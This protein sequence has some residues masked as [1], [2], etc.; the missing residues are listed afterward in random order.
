M[1]GGCVVE[2]HLQAFLAKLHP[3]VVHARGKFWQLFQQHHASGAVHA[4]HRPGDAAVA[5]GGLLHVGLGKGGALPGRGRVR[6]RCW[7][8]GCGGAGG[9]T[10]AV[11]F[12]AVELMQQGVH[13]GTAVTTKRRTPSVAR[14]PGGTSKPQWAQV[15]SALL[16]ATAGTLDTV[17]SVFVLTNCAMSATTAANARRIAGICHAGSN[18]TRRQRSA[19]T[20]S[21]SVTT[22]P[23]ATERASVPA[24]VVPRL[25]SA[26]KPAAGSR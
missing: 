6:S 9:I 13:L 10:Q 1:V 25:A 24:P 2:F 4:A 12:A 18:P 7:L 14:R 16:A 17:T 11:K 20:K 3:G 22:S 19:P 5:A 15:T 8:T 21:R 23:L 26:Q